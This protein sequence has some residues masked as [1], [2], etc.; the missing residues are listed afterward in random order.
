MTYRIKRDLFVERLNAKLKTQENLADAAGVA[1]G[2]IS[3]AL[4]QGCN[5]RNFQAIAEALEVTPHWLDLMV[6]EDR[7]KVDAASRGL[8]HEGKTV[9]THSDKFVLP[10]RATAD[11]IRKTEVTMDNQDNASLLEPRP[12]LMPADQ[13]SRSEGKGVDAPARVALLAAYYGSSG[14][15]D[16][17]DPPV[18]RYCIVVD[19][20]RRETSV[21]T[22]GKRIGMRAALGGVRCKLE[23]NLKAL[24]PP[25][26]LTRQYA[27]K[28]RGRLKD[29]VLED[30]PLYRLVN[31][32]FQGPL[33]ATFT[34]DRYLNYRFTT[35]LLE[36]ELVDVM[37]QSAAAGVSKKQYPLRNLLL[38]DIGAL[39]NCSARC[40]AGGL[41]CV[42]ALAR[43]D[44]EDFL[45][46]I[47][48]RSKFVGDGRGMLAVL[49]KGIHQ[50]E[51]G[52]SVESEIEWSVYRELAEEVFGKPERQHQPRH[53]YYMRQGHP[54][55]IP[56]VAYFREQ[57]RNCYQEMVGFGLNAVS[58]NYEFAILLA[59][60]AEKYYDVFER[61][62][63]FKHWEWD[64][65]IPVSTRDPDHIKE[66]LLDKA[67]CS[68]SVFHLA[69][70][71]LRLAEL[72]PRR[73]RLPKIERDL[74]SI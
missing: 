61:E 68:E 71:L 20:V 46:P 14:T 21:Y 37:L 58:G 41:G 53:D 48:R 30:N 25:A 59:V 3:H 5:L 27:E 43:T 8:P 55:Y 10:V 33:T 57:K 2:T 44:E 22:S 49:P 64:K 52:H 38:P 18:K 73:V 54:L 42:F 62:L 51:I 67:L 74:V 23:R 35:G 31:V 12:L 26:P 72:E 11:E 29:V 56:A 40:C 60:H 70:G 65:W 15:A 7:A 32:T 1:V 28:V 24:P 16:P 17:A 4:R 34:E 6:D 36:D 19:G 63:E 69:E 9:G 39:V 45:I 50:A 13:E 66:V 47:E